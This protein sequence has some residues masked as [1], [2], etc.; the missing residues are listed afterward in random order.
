[1]T[2]HPFNV[3]HYVWV[4][5]TP[6]G[7]EH[8]RRTGEGWRFSHLEE[9]DGW[10]RWQMWGLMATFGPIIHNGCRMPFE[11]TIELELSS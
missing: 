3:N 10:S 5:L 7:V 11:T 6:V 8:L 9:K 1:M 4:K 2:R